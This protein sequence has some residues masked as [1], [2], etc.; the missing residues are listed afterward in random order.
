MR[1]RSWVVFGWCVLWLCSGIV[2]G[3]AGRLWWDTRMRDTAVSYWNTFHPPS[4]TQETVL[5]HAQTGD[6]LL[7]S[8]TTYSERCCQAVLDSVFSHVAFLIRDEHHTVWVW[9][10]D[11]GQGQH[12]GARVMP[13]A[14]KLRM[15]RGSVVAAWKRCTA[16]PPSLSADVPRS[17]QRH[18]TRPF[19]GAMVPWFLDVIGIPHPTRH[20][21]SGKVFCSELVAA[22]SIDVGLLAP[23]RPPHT[24]SPADWHYDTLRLAPGV[25][26]APLLFFRRRT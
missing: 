25:T 17:V 23:E 24:Y 8:G 5:Q 4:T 15:Y 16:H 3:I 14:H 18:L 22:T 21:P 19:D 9:E 1:R 12:K 13:L 6:V 20:P 11:V 7:L 2:L 10:S 26:Y